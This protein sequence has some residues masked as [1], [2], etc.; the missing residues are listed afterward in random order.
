MILNVTCFNL[1]EQGNGSINRLDVGNGDIPS[2][3]FYSFL[4]P[5]FVQGAP[6]GACGGIL[7]HVSEYL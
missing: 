1:T 4:V 3:G 6:F 5:L 2:A 7:D